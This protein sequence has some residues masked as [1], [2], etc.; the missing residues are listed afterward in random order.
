MLIQ[1]DPKKS[2]VHFTGSPTNLVFEFTDSKRS[3]KIQCIGFVV[4]DLYSI[5]GSMHQITSGN[6]LSKTL[7][8]NGCQ[9][10][11]RLKVLKVAQ[12]TSFLS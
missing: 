7:F 10:K 4:A 12:L 5:F 1:K 8:I 3:Q 9:L 6:M 2:S 11:I